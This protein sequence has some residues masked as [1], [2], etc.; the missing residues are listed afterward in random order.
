MDTN[1]DVLHAATGNRFEDG[2]D[3]R[4]FKLIPSA[5]VNKYMLTTSSIKYLED[6]SHT[7]I[8][9]LM[10]KLITGA[11]D[12]DDF[13][14]GF[15]RDRGRRQRELSNDKIIKGKHRVRIMLKDVFGFAEHQDKATYG[16]VYKLTITRNIDKSVLNGDNAIKNAKFKIIAV[17]N[18]VAQYT[19]SI[20]Q[21]AMF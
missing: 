18:Y 12:T 1:F 2:K 19:P 11:R 5:L 13:S 14:I 10:S 4:L 6:V 20:P 17:E 7:H 15:D 16:L 8:V 3:I 21:K 9:S